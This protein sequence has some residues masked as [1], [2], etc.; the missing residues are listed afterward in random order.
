MSPDANPYPIHRVSYRAH[1]RIGR[2]QHTLPHLLKLRTLRLRTL[3]IRRDLRFPGLQPLIHP[4]DHK[5]NLLDM[6]D[7]RFDG[8]LLLLG[9]LILR[10]RVRA[11]ATPGRP[12]FGMRGA[13]SR[14]DWTV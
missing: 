14:P 6:R 12:I 9:L 7:R 10:A 8:L 3:N 5:L 13:T 11:G 2:R 4:K 1:S